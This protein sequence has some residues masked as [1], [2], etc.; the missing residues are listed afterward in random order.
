MTSTPAPRR[1]EPGRRSD[2]AAS[3]RRKS[4]P[5]NRRKREPRHLVRRAVRASGGL[6]RTVVKVAVV[7][8]VGTAAVLGVRVAHA[9]LLSSE[10]FALRRIEVVGLGRLQKDEVLAKGGIREGMNVLVLD[11]ALA[12]EA[13]EEIPWIRRAKV[14]RRLPDRVRV[15]VEERIPVAILSTGHLYLVD[16][17][18][19]VF[20]RLAPG[21]PSDLCTVSGIPRERFQK[22]K[23][24]ATEELLE[25]LGLARAY[26]EAG[27][28]LSEPISEVHLDSDGGW[29]IF[30]EKDGGRVRVGE[31]PFR[32]KL[33]RLRLV[34]GELRQMRA[35]AEYILLD[36][37]VR[38]DR[39]TVRLRPR[40]AP[41]APPV[42]P[43]GSGPA[44]RSRRADVAGVQ[45]AL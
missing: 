7:L 23:Q 30:L 28:S 45:A 35:R 21:D 3:A 5:P 16:E 26:E 36:N 9:R 20:K 43:A 14:A 41:P 19:E 42:E 39:A 34:L 40:P 11:P 24:R 22:S 29:S 12:A 4:S 25:G 18:G 2:P 32:Q 17:R 38:P 31:M 8:A 27:L 15:E 13:I 6:V 33:R 44:K 1:S 10:H 37:R